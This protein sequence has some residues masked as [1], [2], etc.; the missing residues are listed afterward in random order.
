MSKATNNTQVE[1]VEAVR[2]LA[3]KMTDAV[4]ERACGR[5]E[6]IYALPEEDMDEVDEAMSVIYP[7]D[8]SPAPGPL[9]VIAA[10]ERLYVALGNSMSHDHRPLSNDTDRCAADVDEAWGEIYRL[11]KANPDPRR[12]PQCQ[13]CG[14]PSAYAISR[15]CKPCNPNECGTC[16]AFGAHR[17]GRKAH[18]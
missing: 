6:N 4:V 17:T 15:N 1:T 8:G 13:A 3:D 2:A 10:A 14:E 18:V 16:G 5:C 12:G 11:I 9:D 7:G